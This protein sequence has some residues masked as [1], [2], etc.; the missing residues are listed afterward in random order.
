MPGLIKN[1][2]VSFSFPAL[3]ITFIIGSQFTFPRE[4]N[5]RFGNRCAPAVQSFPTYDKIKLIIEEAVADALKTAAEFNMILESK[6]SIYHI[7]I[8]AA[9]ETSEE[10]NENADDQADELLN[11]ENNELQGIV[12]PSDFN[13]NE[14]DSDQEFVSQISKLN[15]LDLKDCSNIKFPEKSCL[16]V[17]LANGKMIKVKKST[18]CWFFQN[19]KGRLSSDRLVRVRGMTKQKNERKSKESMLSKS[20]STYLRNNGKKR[21]QQSE[22]ETD[23]SESETLDL[24]YTDSEDISDENEETIHGDEESKILM[25]KEHIYAIFYDE[26]WYLGRIIDIYPE[27]V[28][29]KF[30]RKTI[31]KST[32]DFTWS[33][34]HETYNVK[35]EYVFYGPINLIGNDPFSLKRS[36]KIKINERYKSLKKVK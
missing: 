26:D 23:E 28:K 2:S 16:T 1:R 17:Q 9:V 30:L 10:Q 35:K 34:K 11:N 20:R 14:H 21:K 25:H 29:V 5:K 27:E 32:E 18:L 22:T 7:S 19:K 31:Q 15:S 24:T 4:N 33:H 12:L 13:E 36:D 3:Y 8:P 6:E